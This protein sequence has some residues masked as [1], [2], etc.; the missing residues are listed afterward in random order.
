[1]SFY[2]AIRVGAA[3]AGDYEIKRSL[4]FNSA[5]STYLSRT[6]SSAGNRKTFTF[7]AWVKRSKLGRAVIL[8]VATSLG[9]QESG[10]EFDG[11]IIRCYQ[12][13][14]SFNFRIR[15]NAQYRDLSAW[16][17]IVFALDTTQ[18]SSNNRAKL[19]VNGE[20]VT[21][22]N[23][24]EQPSQNLDC[25]FLNTTTEH[26]IGQLAGSQ[27]FDGYMAEIN[28]ID[29]LQL[30]PSSFGETNAG[31]GQWNPKKY[32]GSYGSNGFYLPLTDNSGTTATTLGKD[33]SGNGHNFTPNNFSVSD[34]VKDSPTNNFATLDILAES[35]GTYSEGNLKAVGASDPFSSTIGFASGKFYYEAYIDATT[36]IYVGVIPI[37]YGLNPARGGGWNHGAIAYRS[38]GQQYKLKSGGGYSSVSTSYGAS[39]TAGDIIGCAVDIDNDTVTFYKNGV[40]QGNTSDGVSYITASGTTSIYGAIVYSNGGN[41]TF[42]VNFGQDSTFQGTVSAGGNTDAN[43]IGDFKYTVPTGFKALCSANL[44]DPTILLPNKHF[45]TLL[46]TGQDTSSLYNVTGLEFQPDWVWGKA[47]ND[48]IGHILFDSV[49]GEDRQLETNNTDAEVLRSSAAYRFLSN[50]FAVSTVGNLNNPVNYVAWNWNAGATDSATYTVKVVSDS[51]NKYRFNDFGTSAVTLDLAE[52]GTYTFDGSDSSMSGHPFVIG[53]AAN[54]SVYSTGVTYQLDGVSVTYSAYTSGYSSAT[55][56]KLII[57]VPASAPQLYYWCSIHSGMGGAI[58]TNTSLGSSNF[59]G[60]IQSTVKANTTAGFSIVTY[61][62]TSASTATI[63][64]GLGVTPNVIIVRERDDTSQWA[65][66]QTQLGFGNKLNLNST[67]ASGGSSLMNSTSPTSTVFTVKNTSSGDV[68][69]NGGLFLAYCFSEVAGYSKFGSYTGNGV[70]DGTFVYTGFRVAWLMTKRSSAARNWI[71]YD[72]K[73]GPFNEVDNF[74]EADTVNTEDPKDMIDFTANGFKLRDSDTDVNSSGDTYI[75]LAFAEAPFR[76]ARAR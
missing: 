58:N 44:P 65:Y 28:F 21:D 37:D 56:R 27:K 50:G 64:H 62:G 68:L 47:R 49:R 29:G 25:S 61:T 59:A 71:I 63:G 52:G 9:S 51:G 8:G 4:R 2:D 30:T 41:N 10:I 23:A 7:S 75:Y 42:R 66:F 55:T 14:G 24:N 76:N 46:Y 6:P 34:V 40:S 12:Y 22:L 33:S 17:H 57:T 3:G 15:T 53:T 48:T 45:D 11:D 31:T 20:Q 19:Y 35:G 39:Y 54:G 73:R 67:D 74:L 16:L 38:S 1:M 36:N 60:S 5:D 69:N 18:A 43:G 70:A 26:R 13:T 72:N 32:V